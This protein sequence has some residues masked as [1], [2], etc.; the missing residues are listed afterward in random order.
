[1]PLS[2]IHK[3]K[4]AKNWMVL[5]AIAG[6]IVLIWAITMIKLANGS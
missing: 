6:W 4:Q 5:G 1:M 3:K 2:E